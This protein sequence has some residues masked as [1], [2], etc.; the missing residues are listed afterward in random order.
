MKKIL[1]LFVFIGV[2]SFGQEK[3]NSIKGKVTYLNTP[4]VNAKIKI[5]DSDEVVKTDME[6]KYQLTAIPG[7][8]IGFS[9]PN[10]RTVEIVVE[11]VTRILNIE[12]TPKVTELDEV[13]VSKTVLKSQKQLQREYATN[14]NLINTAF[15]ILDRETSPGKM[16]LL[17]KDDMVFPGLCILDLL[18]SRFSGV[19]VYGDCIRGGGV[20]VRGTESINNEGNTIYDVDGL[21]LLD[22]PIWILPENIERM[23]VLSSR[24]VAVRYGSVGA[25][26]V[27]VIN[28]R[29]GNYFPEPGTDKP[30][31][32]AKLRNNIFQGDAVSSGKLHNDKPAYL[33]Q[34]LQSD[35]YDKAVEVYKNQIKIYNTS[36]YYV[37]D[38]YDYFFNH[39]K[40]NDFADEIIES[41]K[42]L[43]E[44]NPL[45]SKALAYM[46]QV[47]GRLEKAHETYKETFILRPNYAQSYMDLANSYRDIGRHKKAA[48]IYA[49]YGHLLEEG[50]LRAEGDLGLIMERE[51]NNLITLKGRDLLSKQELNDLILDDDFDGTRLV[52]EWNDNEAEFELQFVN[53]DGNYYKSEHSLSADPDRIKQ[54]K[55]SGFS[56]EEYLIDDSV[57][58]VWKINI[59]YLGNKSLTPTYLKAT[60]YH[61]YGSASQRKETKVFKLSVKNINQ[62]L[63]IVSNMVS[64][65]SN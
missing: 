44:D 7:Q 1:S 9:Y 2:L 4:L 61:N 12:L 34:L 60:I 49:R 29:A 25:G 39:W 35:S 5:T 57:K 52:F 55:I 19:S 36:F 18:R 31:D 64:V 23:A 21:I 24:S 58:G 28:S 59:K 51:L 33:M 63:F 20:T 8:I 38:A 46:Y 62:Q 32:Q 17:T 16:S 13:V 43:F 40:N 45:A 22:V 14:K 10:M 53:P 65:V 48:V 47:G 11:D 56:S 54:E 27:V 37:L 30:Y 41:N 3:V 6:G 15:G 42:Q 26:G 50:F